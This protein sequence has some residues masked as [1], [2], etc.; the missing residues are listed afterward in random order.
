MA[1][2]TITQ[3]PE[4]QRR[5]SGLRDGEETLARALGWFS[6]GLGFAQLAAPR[7]LSQMIGAPARPRLMRA[8][9]ARELASGIGILGGRRPAPWVWARVGGDVIDLALLAAALRAAETR[10]GRAIAA[11]AAV[12]GVTIAD[13]ICSARLLRSGAARFEDSLELTASV[14]INRPPAEAYRFW[15]DFENHPRFMTHLESVRTSGDGRSHWRLR[16]PGGTSVEWDAEITEDVPERSLAWRTTG[17]PEFAHSGAVRFEPGPRGQG[18]VVELRMRYEP[19]AGRL[20]QAVA[21]LLGQA[22]EQQI[23]DELRRFKQL[24]ET[25]EI[26]RT[27]GQPTGRRTSVA[28]ALRKWRE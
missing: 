25:G 28:R 13:A 15:R 27:E 7:G 17:D 22:P 5:A 24:L 4:R 26:A 1:T 3:T 2:Q 11:T 14:T 8:L 19:P 16:G 20:G 10:R 23:E 12:A 18:T 6:V 9:G 21:M